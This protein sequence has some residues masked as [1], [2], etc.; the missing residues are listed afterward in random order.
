MQT[1][2]NHVTLIGSLSS[3]PEI[4]NFEN[5]RKVARFRVATNRYTMKDKKARVEWHRVFAWGNMA[6]FMENHAKIG[7]EL[8]IHGRLVHR[9]Y[10][11]KDGKERKITEVEVKHVIGL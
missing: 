2:K 1:L 11:N 10:L 7:N 3:K 4:T 9:T 8:A 5:G 6:Q